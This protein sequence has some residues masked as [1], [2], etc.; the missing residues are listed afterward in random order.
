MMKSMAYFYYSN[1]FL[2]NQNSVYNNIRSHHHRNFLLHLKEFLVIHSQ[3]K[4]FTQCGQYDFSNVW[5][6]SCAS[7]YLKNDSNHFLKLK[8][9]YLHP[10][11]NYSKINIAIHYYV[12][13]TLNLF[14]FNFKAFDYFMKNIYK[15]NRNLMRLKQLKKWLG[16]LIWLF[17]N[18]KDFILQLPYKYQNYNFLLSYSNPNFSYLNSIFFSFCIHLFNENIYC[19][20]ILYLNHKYLHHFFNP[21]KWAVNSIQMSNILYYNLN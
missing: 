3:I 13:Q 8:I 15:N 9:A 1:L 5:L 11:S 7:Y 4:A 12:Y 16:T 17:N 21:D 14:F 20:G 2:N 6:N 10:I 19:W 18:Q